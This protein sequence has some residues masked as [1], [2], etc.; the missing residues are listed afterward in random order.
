[1]ASQEGIEKLYYELASESRL[2]ILREIAKQDSKMRNIACKLDLTVTETFRQLQRLTEA[3]LVQKTPEGAYS[4]TEY[5]R[6]V[7]QLSASYD[8]LFKHKAYFATHD[9]KW[10]PHQ[11]LYRIGELDSAVLFTDTVAN[12]NTV[13]DL[14]KA[15]QYMWGGGPE[16]PLNLRPIL[17]QNIPK[18]ATYR[19]LFPKRFVTARKPET[20]SAIEWRSIEDLPASI[21]LTEKGAGVCFPLVGGKVDYAGFGGRDP[22][23]IN[24]VKDLFLYY[25]DKG[26]RI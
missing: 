26:Q 13:L 6:I 22:V 12:I 2:G 4:I 25:W 7:L 11:F 1:L 8:F 21:I 9:L 23:F 16:Q 3:L 14:T 10:L 19:F 5:G 18:G 24:W 17:L 15:G 20:A